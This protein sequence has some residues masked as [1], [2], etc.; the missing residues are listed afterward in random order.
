MRVAI[1][2]VAAA[3]AAAITFGSVNAASAQQAP[4][5]PAPTPTASPTPYASGTIGGALAIFGIQSYPG[6][7]NDDAS[8]MLVNAS[9]TSGYYKFSA[10]G[11][12]Y[13][14][15]VIGTPVAATY[16]SL[17][18]L[19]GGATCANTSCFTA[20][21]L[22]QV[23]YTSPDS[24]WT[25]Y[26]GKLGT[27]LG[28]EGAFTYQN[29]NIER[30]L[31]W[32]LEPVVSRGVHA[33]YTNGPWT[34]A[35][36]YNDGF[37]TGS[38]RAI[39]YEVAWAPSSAASWTFV[40]FNPGGNTP[41]NATAAI[42]NASEYNLVYSRTAGK[43]QFSPYLLWVESPASPVL[44]YASSASDYAL[45]FLGSYAF[46]PLYS[47]GFRVEDA[48]NTA[49]TTDASPNAALLFGPGSGAT[50]YTLT[51]SYK[52]AG[53]GLLRIEWSHVSVRNGPFGSQNRIG[54]EFGASK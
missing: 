27:L 16:N 23:T 43:W 39:E 31:G 33:G 17:P 5:S 18:G 32:A 45:S 25:V 50:T 47:I 12:G 19:T 51:P 4:P 15:P 52:F 8:D 20:L 36:E 42:A 14:F 10:T 3:A 40:G 30:G 21:P 49:A 24:H 34:F 28:S 22:V 29:V 54:F 11:G 44:G 35:A 53:N 41:G 38:H 6:G 2:A 7:G 37:Y 46:S 48:E 26:A 1:L 9:Y 13:N